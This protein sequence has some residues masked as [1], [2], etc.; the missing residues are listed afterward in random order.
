[1]DPRAQHDAAQTLFPRRR[2][3]QPSAAK[4]SGD[5]PAPG[6]THDQN[7]P[8]SPPLQA[9]QPQRL[10]L[11]LRQRRHAATAVPIAPPKVEPLSSRPVPRSRFSLP[12]RSAARGS[13]PPPFHSFSS[14][15]QHSF[16]ELSSS[17]SSSSSHTSS[18]SSLL[19]VLADE[20]ETCE[21][22]LSE[23]DVFEEKRDGDMVSVPAG[24]K[25]REFVGEGS[26]NVVVGIEL[27]EGTPIATRRFFEG[28]GSRCRVVLLPVLL[29]M[30][31]RKRVALY[32]FIY[33]GVWGTNSSIGKLLRLQKVPDNPEK[34]P[35][36]YPEQYRY[37]R[38]HIK[39][40][41]SDT[42]DLVSVDLVHLGPGGPQLLDDVSDLLRLLDDAS[43]REQASRDSG[44]TLPGLNEHVPKRK[45]KFRGSKLARVEYAMLVDD[46]RVGMFSPC[47]LL[48]PTCWE[49]QKA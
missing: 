23:P 48:H 32:I 36:P 15:E 17:L 41:F 38:E 29:S 24:A 39:P 45:K 9:R 19:T 47:S 44:C 26:A 40:F 33:I 16:P 10:R 14:H 46:M 27:P 31:G 28:M 7:A 21:S 12:E 20:D 3:R 49:P 25:V 6:A 13:P 34:R 8:D 30:T 35:Y 37:W 4:G 11:S 18:T 42:D 22:S 43:E 5:A 1:M 2:P